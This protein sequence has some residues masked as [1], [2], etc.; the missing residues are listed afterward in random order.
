MAHPSAYSAKY[1]GDFVQVFD[2]LTGAPHFSIHVGARGLTTYF[3]SGSTFTIT[4]K[5]G[6]TEVWDLNNRQKLR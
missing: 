1:T 5:T 6:V 2:A 3:M 4:Y